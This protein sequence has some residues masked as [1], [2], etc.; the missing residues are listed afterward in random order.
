MLVLFVVATN[1]RQ[2]KPVDFS[3]IKTDGARVRNKSAFDAPKR[4]HTS[5]YKG[6]ESS[7][8]L[9]LQKRKEQI[10]M[11]VQLVQ[12]TSSTSFLSSREESILEAHTEAISYRPVLSAKHKK[13]LMVNSN[14]ADFQRCTSGYPLIHSKRRRE[15]KSASVYEKTMPE[16]GTTARIAIHRNKIL[17]AS[18]IPDPVGNLDDI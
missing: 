7:P 6:R 12:E 8:S 9:R 15:V 18:P 14:G 5:H 17:M 3:W 1:D 2:A 10:Q 16:P 4:P 13:L 11:P